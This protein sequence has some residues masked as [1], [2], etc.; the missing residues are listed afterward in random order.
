M[1]RHESLSPLVEALLFQDELGIRNLLQKVNANETDST[2]C[3]PLM[4]AAAKNPLVIV[5]ALVGAG[6]EVNKGDCDGFTPLMSAAG[7]GR[8]EIVRYFLNHGAVVDVADKFGHTALSW[9]VTKGDFDE[10]ANLLIEYG[11][12]V[13]GADG[14]GF[15]PL[16]R[17]A[18]MEHLRCFETLVRHG[19]NVDTIHPQ[20]RKTA[21]QIATEHGS[22]SLKQL[23]QRLQRR[24]G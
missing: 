24:D 23:V 19:A 4:F 15:T 2:G 8:T 16:M 5:E 22:D 11:A 7:A 3:T 6:A 1:E 14:G 9:A 12:N 18:L 21:F 17:S 13:N 10:A 20:W